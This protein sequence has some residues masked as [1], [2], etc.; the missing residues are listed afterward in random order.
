MTRCTLCPV[1]CGADRTLRAGR[2]GVKGLTVAKYGLHRF[3]EPPVSHRNGSGAI[4]FGGCHLRCC[5]CQNYEVSR[6]VRGKEI[7]VSELC[8]V[9]RRLEDAGAENINL[10]TPDHVSSLI[11]RA[12]ETYKPHVPVVYN[13]SGYCKLSALREIDPMID[14]YL[15]DVKFFSPKLSER[16][17][18]RADYFSYAEQA[19]AFMAKKPRRESEDGKLLSG[20]IVRHL[21]LPM[22]G[23]DSRNVLSFLHETLPDDAPVSLMRQYLPMGEASRFPELTRRVTDREYARVKDFALSLGFR[24]LYVQDRE[25]ADAAFIPDWDF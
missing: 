1:E 5:F 10:V 3:E 25:S 4:F 7:S 23:E 14:V 16:Y 21:V 13:S 6:A 2:C 20:I 18:G 9:F 8:D 24:T 22:C 12:L 19:I 11:A 17:T 15:P